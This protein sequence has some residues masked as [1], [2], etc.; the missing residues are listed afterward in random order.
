MR[1]AIPMSRWSYRIWLETKCP[2][3]VRTLISHTAAIVYYRHQTRV[4]VI[5]VLVCDDAGQCILLADHL[6]LCAE[7]ERL[8]STRS[9]YDALND[10]IAMTAAKQCELLTEL[11]HQLPYTTIRRSVEPV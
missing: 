5:Q 4:P 10:R 3:N 7:F 8:F 9:G 1:F 6:G 11:D 2:A